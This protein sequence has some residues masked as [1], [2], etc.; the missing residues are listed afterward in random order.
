MSIFGDS[1]WNKNELYSNI[2]SFFKEGGSI[3]ELFEVVHTVFQY[4]YTPNEILQDRI[5]KAYD[6]LSEGVKFCK[7]DSQGLYEKCN[8]AIQREERVMAILKGE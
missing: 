3:E 6:E 8:I 4:G 5:N 7:N 2:E 1:N